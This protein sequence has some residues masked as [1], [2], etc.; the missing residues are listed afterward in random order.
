MSDADLFAACLRS[1]DR[2]GHGA[3]VFLRYADDL[4]DR[5][6]IKLARTR[7]PKGRILGYVAELGTVVAFQAADVL[8]FLNDELM[9]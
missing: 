3:P 5:H 9:T 2:A 8:A 6:S 4:G 1:I 7:G